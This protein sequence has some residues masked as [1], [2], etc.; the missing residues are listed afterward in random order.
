MHHLERQEP[1][2]SILVVSYNCAADLLRCL[3]SVREH[4]RGVRWEVLVRD[5]DS[6]DADQVMALAGEDVRVV[7]GSDNPG[8]GKANNE[9]ARMARGDFLLLLNPDTILRSDVPTALRDALLANSG[10]GAVAPLLENPDG[11]RQDTW[12]PPQGLLW[13]F[14][15]GHYLQ[16]LVRARRWKRFDARGES[17]LFDVGFAGGACLM[18]RREVFLELGGFDPDFFLNHEDLELCDR[19]RARGLG[20]A[21]LPGHRVIHAEGTS[22]RKDW[23]A[24]ARNRLVS[25]W[26]YLRKRFQGPSLVVARLL[27]WESLVLKYVVG[28]F[29]LRGAARSRLDGFRSAASEVLGR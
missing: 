29:V 2:V 19:V 17:A 25:K 13:E 24:Y 8:F 27:W 9:V 14:C 11:S 6:R 22:Q 12:A 5:N 21:I 28:W 3:D 7:A 20:I 1:E 23:S 10:L 18:L 4:V 15:E 16:G 26:T